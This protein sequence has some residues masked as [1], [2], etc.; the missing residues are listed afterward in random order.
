MNLGQSKLRDSTLFKNEING[1]LV[2]NADNTGKAMSEIDLSS[3]NSN[4]TIFYKNKYG[5]ELNSKLFTNLY[6]F[7]NGVVLPQTNSINLFSNNFSGTPLNTVLSAGAQNDSVNYMLGQGGTLIKV[8]LPTLSNLGK[9]AVNKAVLQVTQIIPNSNLSFASPATATMFLV[10][11]NTDGYLD[12]IPS[13]IAPFYNGY[14]I[15]DSVGTDI[16]GNKFV[17]Y[18]INISKHIQDISKGTLINSD[19]YIST[20]RTGGTDGTKNLL[21]T[22]NYGYT[23]YRVILAGSNYS[24]VRYKMKL[25]LTYTLIK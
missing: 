17:R 3:I 13:Y 9:V 11:R 2:D 18:T 8:S 16:A 12:F 22:Y 25:N 6:R 24:D 1:I 4:V 20:Y 10:K 23:P 14:S 5:K 21:S 19:L 15:V 7:V